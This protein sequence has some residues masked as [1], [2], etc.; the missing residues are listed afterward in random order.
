[1]IFERTKKAKGIEKMQEYVKQ[2]YMNINL[3][4][5]LLAEAA[6]YSPYYFS[7]IFREITGQNVTDYI[8]KI[9]INKAKELLGN[10][11]FR[12]NEIYTLIGFTN[13]SQ[14]YSVFKKDVGL[15][16]MAY[17]EYTLKDN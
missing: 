5:E 3:S 14:F 17:R 13:I 7:K 11:N 15:T 9:R 1:M 10:D 16:P 2:N 6:G 12:V 8:R 4:V